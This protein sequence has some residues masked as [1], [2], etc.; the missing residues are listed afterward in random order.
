MT[1]IPH[2]LLIDDDSEIQRLLTRYLTTNG[3]RVTVGGD[4]RAMHQALA[5]WQID[6]VILDIMLPGDDG[7]ALC[8]QLRQAGRLPVIM[9]T[10]MTEDSDRIQGLELGADDY[11]IKPFNPRELL[12]RIHAV[13][14]RTED[15]G[16]TGR[17][18]EEAPRSLRF[19]GWTLDRAAR[20][21]HAP[22]GTVVHLSGGEFALLLA[23]LKNP[24]RVLSRDQLADM[25]RGQSATPFDRSIDIQISRLRR[26]IEP[27]P[28]D[29]SLI[30]TVH[31]Q[32]YQFCAD[33][34]SGGEA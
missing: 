14:R 19:L 2:I 30:K 31:G 15:G 24:Q 27:N 7:F 6:L 16:Q 29:P 17:T 33:V 22:D 8:R 32:G 26:K 25:A 10:A 5:D 28:K 3:L 23:F 1:R 13:L 12:A 20:E 21:L 4:G 18:T 11:V 34:R 9:L